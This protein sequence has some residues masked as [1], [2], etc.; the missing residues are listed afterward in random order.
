VLN[1]G[2]LSYGFSFLPGVSVTVTKFQVAKARDVL[3][4]SG[5]RLF[6]FQLGAMIAGCYQSGMATLP[7][8]PTRMKKA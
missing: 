2:T 5:I 8:L 1:R 6:G 3:G 7:V 4:A